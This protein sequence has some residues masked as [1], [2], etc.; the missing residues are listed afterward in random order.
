MSLSWR[1]LEEHYGKQLNL[2]RRAGSGATTYALD[3]Y[4]DHWEVELKVRKMKPKG[5]VFLISRYLLQ[6]LLVRS[7]FRHKLPLLLL[8]FK[9]NDGK[10]RF[11]VVLPLVENYPSS[12]LK[13]F[14]ATKDERIPLPPRKGVSITVRDG[15]FYVHRRPLPVLLWVAPTALLIAETSPE[16]LKNFLAENPL[17]ED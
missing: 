1:R 15:Q 5:K 11:V 7:F 17:K 16:Q 14:G 9:E 8:V 4:N 12:V 3:L 6:E 13:T 10:E 2:R